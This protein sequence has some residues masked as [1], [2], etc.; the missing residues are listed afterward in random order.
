MKVTI[1]S[2]FSVHKVLLQTKPAHFFILQ[3]YFHTVV[4]GLSSW[5]RDPRVPKAQ[6]I[7]SLAFTKIC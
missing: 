6:S 4:A 7:Y 5:E 2:N 3:G 1:N